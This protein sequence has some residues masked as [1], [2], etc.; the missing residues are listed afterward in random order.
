MNPTTETPRIYVACLAAYNNGRLHGAWIDVDQEPE[1]IMTEISAML[2][3][4]PESGAEE[5]GIH[6]Y[7]NFY[8]LS[9]SEHESIE[10][11]SELAHFIVEHGK[12]GAKVLS[13]YGN[14]LD[15][16]KQALEDHYC[17][18]HQSLE[19]YAEQFAEDCGYLSQVPENLRAYI[20]FERLGRD[21]ELN[22]DIFTIE[23]SYREIHVFWSH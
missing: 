5:W 20:D 18:E 9:L 12:L 11:V 22:G 13:H 19:A 15:D 3:D 8:S 6:D 21:L 10:H 1:A 17:G 7:D 16:A 2:A 23:T 14:D 4:S